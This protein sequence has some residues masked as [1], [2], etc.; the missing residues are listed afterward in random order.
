[1]SIWYCDGLERFPGECQPARRVEASWTL[2][3]KVE[4]NLYLQQST[5]LHMTAIEE[6]NQFH[7]RMCY[8]ARIGLVD[9]ICNWPYRDTS[10]RERSALCF[11]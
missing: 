10:H 9:L 5:G 7:W 11:D 6:C 4:W 1:M 2:D 8:A 3:A